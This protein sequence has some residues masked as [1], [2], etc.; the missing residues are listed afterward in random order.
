[1]ASWCRVRCLNQG[2]VHEGAL[3]AVFLSS[4]GGVR[5]ATHKMH[6]APGFPLLL[7]SPAESCF[8]HHQALKLRK[9][10]WPHLQVVA[11]EDRRRLL[12]TWGKGRQSADSKGV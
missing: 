10:F 12:Q 5:N 1:M 7:V 3:C 9:R 11:Q 2:I 4:P 6:S 8:G